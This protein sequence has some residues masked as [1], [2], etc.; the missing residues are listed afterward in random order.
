MNSFHI[1][2]K[3]G[4]YQQFD[5]GTNLPNQLRILNVVLF[6]RSVQKQH[7]IKY[8]SHISNYRGY[9]AVTVFFHYN[10]IMKKNNQKA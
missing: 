2:N 10:R 6:L 7:N 3:Q 5:I 4:Y 8:F 1:S 9:Y